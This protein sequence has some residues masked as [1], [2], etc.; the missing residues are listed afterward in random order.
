MI[1]VLAIDG[2]SGSGKGAVG[3]A[4]ALALG[5]HYL[6]SGAVYRALAVAAL[7]AGVA[8][9]DE[10]G[11]EALAGTLDLRF[12][13]A[14]AG[15]DLAVTLNGRECAARLRAPKT[16]EAA[17]RIAV[18]PG[19]RVAL[20]ARQKAARRAPGLVADGRDMG[21]TVFPDAFLKIFLTASAEV[22]AKRR[23]DQLKAKGF[24]VTLS[25]LI[26]E[27]RERDERDAQRAVAPL[28]PALGS[29]V[30]DSSALGLQDVIER[31]LV[32]ARKRLGT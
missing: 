9:D 7:E 25:Q 18:L 2:P 11:L 27:I 26:R 20:L 21:S 17:S 31:V 4:V 30:L 1:P 12:A 5:W 15:E 13:P 16:A 29:E 14:P 8:L 3:A 28:R 24:G 10:A 32:L 22:R 19:V 6:D 23:Y